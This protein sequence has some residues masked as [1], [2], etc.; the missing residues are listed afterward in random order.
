MTAADIMLNLKLVSVAV[1]KRGRN[2]AMPFLEGGPTTVNKMP[3]L[4]VGF[5]LFGLILLVMASFIRKI[6]TRFRNMHNGAIG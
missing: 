6:G 1:R 5:I 4:V 3:W 2:Y